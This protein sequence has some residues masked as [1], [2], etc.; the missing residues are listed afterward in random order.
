MVVTAFVMHPFA[1]VIKQVYVPA[2]ME[3]AT[4]AL[5]PTGDQ[6]YVKAPVPPVAEAVAE[7]VLV[8]KQLIFV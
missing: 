1:S 4:A 3:F 5:P 2:G 6:E 8:P 7:P